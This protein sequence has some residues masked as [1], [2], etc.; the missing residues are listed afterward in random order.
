[1]K[2]LKLRFYR[3]IRCL[4]VRLTWWTRVQE[5]KE[6]GTYAKFQEMCRRL[7]DEIHTP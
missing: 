4:A 2:K 7:Q 1:M 6:N 5:M 3:C